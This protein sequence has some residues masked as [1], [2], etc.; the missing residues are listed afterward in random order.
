MGSFGISQ[1]HR[2]CSMIVARLYGQALHCCMVGTAF[3]PVGM[4][5]R[6]AQLVDGAMLCTLINSIAEQDE[7]GLSWVCTTGNGDGKC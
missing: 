7:L 4:N 1:V 2:D 6:P 3:A 5:A